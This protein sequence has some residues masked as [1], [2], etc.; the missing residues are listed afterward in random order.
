MNVFGSLA[1]SAIAETLGEHP[2]RG[3][4]DSSI[5]LSYE[6]YEMPRLVYKK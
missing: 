1:T 3:A 2:A 6:A 5:G 4:S